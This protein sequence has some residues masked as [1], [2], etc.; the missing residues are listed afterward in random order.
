[1]DL[2]CDDSKSTVLFSFKMVNEQ[3]VGD[4]VFFRVMQGTVKT[5]DDFINSKTKSGEKLGAMFSVMGKNR[6][7]VGELHAGDMGCTVK[8]RD[9][10]ANQ[11][12]AVKGCDI[13]VAPIIFPDPVMR[14]AIRPAKDEDEEKMSTGLIQFR[15]EDPSFQIAQDP[16]LGQTILSGQGDQQL[17]LLSGQAARTLRRR[18]HHG[19]APRALSRDHH[20]QLRCQVPP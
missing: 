7:D 10:S 13:E 2:P 17:K 19:Q 12:L 3:H 11:T 15:R 14:T 20:G 16:E 5:G 9:T 4:L 8:L 6:S 1:M 18:C